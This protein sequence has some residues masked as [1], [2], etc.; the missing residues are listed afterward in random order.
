MNRVTKI[1][2]VGHCVL[3]RIFEVD[4]LP[5]TGQKIAARNSRESG[6]GPASTAAVAIARLGAEAAYVGHVGDDDTGA[7]L[8]RKIAELGVDAGGVIVVEG[9]RTIAPVVLVDAAGERCI[10]VHRRKTDVP[11]TRMRFDFTGVD[12]L[13][14]DT[15][16]T[17]GAEAALEEARRI[18]VPTVIDVDG[19]EREANLRLVAQCDH[20]IFSDQ[21][22]REFA[23]EGD[24][25]T[26]LRSAAQHCP[27]VVAVTAGAKGS[28][29]LI[30][31]AA[32]HVPAFR[33]KPVDTTGCGDV[34][35]G[36]Y[37]LGAAEGMKPLDAAR[38]AAAA[39]ALKAERG[40]GWDGM[41]DRASVEALM[42][43]G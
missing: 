28:Y 11:R 27:G 39:A 22:L 32:A 1:L 20:V 13:L 21:G 10:I 40:Q 35:H 43:R 8:R 23:G 37:A 17:A 15:R 26:Q 42:A 24:L 9:F 36:A 7:A 16:W 30:D 18:R 12:M 4:E 19:G 2:C 41:P 29:W 14:V 38:F 5:R 3:D 34:F 31:G 33:V 25:E 6:G